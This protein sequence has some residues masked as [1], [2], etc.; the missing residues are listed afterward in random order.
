[1][2]KKRVAVSGDRLIDAQ[3]SFD[4]NNEPVVSFRF[5]S[6]GG[7]RFADITR[8][9]VNKPFAIV[10]DNRVISAPVIREP[11]LGGSGHFHPKLVL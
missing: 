9:N 5:D 11:I 7:K 4:Q 10:L 1:M 2:I 6:V 8:R 3:P